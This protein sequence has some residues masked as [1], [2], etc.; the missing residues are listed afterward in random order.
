MHANQVVSVKQH[1]TLDGKIG[2]QIGGGVRKA[3][4]LTKPLMVHFLKNDVAPKR[5][6]FEFN[7]TPNAV[8][9]VGT[10]ISAQ[11]FCVGQ[12]LDVQ[13][14][15]RGKGFAG[16]MKRHGF[17]GQGASH[18]NSKAHRAIGSTGASTSPGRVFKGKR[19]PGQMGNVKRTAENLRLYKIDLARDLLYVIGQVPGAKGNWVRVRDSIKKTQFR[20]EPLPIPTHVAPEA[21]AEADE[22]APTEI[23]MPSVP[24]MYAFSK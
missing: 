4:H 8:P 7:V 10:R 22:D 23:V 24:D 2:V 9:D 12:Y 20:T 15:S 6:I 16:A 1:Q 19:M 3:K 5:K 11:H 21:A 17:A 13:G 18:G 14:I